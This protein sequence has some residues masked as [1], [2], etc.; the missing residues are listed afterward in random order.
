MPETTIDT[1]GG[2]SIRQPRHG[3][4]FSMEPVLLSAF[5][6]LK[7]PKRIAD[8]GAGTGVI[9]LLLAQ[10][11]GRAKIT[12]VELQDEL[13]E[14]CLFNIENN[15]LGQRVEA[16]RSDI[17][18]LRPALTGL[19][20]VVSNPPFRRPGT[21]RIS[22]KGKGQSALARHEKGLQ[23]RE[24]CRAAARALRGR[25]RFCLAYHPDRLVE[26]MDSLRA[27]RLEP[28]R[29]RFVHGRAG[30]E[31]RIILMEAVRDGNPGMKVEPPLY[32]YKDASGEYTDEVSKMYLT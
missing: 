1:I 29:L 16:I 5:V 31:A 12:L 23:L 25:G 7:A 13:Y 22:T 21:G 6:G 2:L 8:F 4:R 24:L 17:R 26:L 32:V 30:L 3:Y 18:K 14:L 28:K 20:I 9:G 11:F 10:R 15:S 19:D 27:A